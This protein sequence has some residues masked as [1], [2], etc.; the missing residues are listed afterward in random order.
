M[1]S[2]RSIHHI[3][4]RFLFCV[5]W[6]I[7][8]PVWLCFFVYILQWRYALPWQILWKSVGYDALAGFWWIHWG[9]EGRICFWWWGIDGYR[10]WMAVWL[11]W[12]FYPFLT[13]MK[14]PRINND[15]AL[16]NQLYKQ[17]SPITLYLYLLSPFCPLSLPNPDVNYKKQNNKVCLIL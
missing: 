12:V 4:Y 13:I 5:L 7:L 9:W 11:V 16:R 1:W 10:Y 3:L 8:Q 6:V 15:L 2:C 14:E 17:L